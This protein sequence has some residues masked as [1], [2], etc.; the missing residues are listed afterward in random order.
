MDNKI[1]KGNKDNKKNS[2]ERKATKNVE[3]NITKYKR[4]MKPNEY[5]KSEKSKKF[6]DKFVN[7]IQKTNTKV[8]H[9]DENDE[10]NN[11]NKFRNIVNT[12]MDEIEMNE[13]NNYNY[14]TIKVPLK[15]ELSDS[16][17]IFNLD[18]NNNNDKE[19]I[20][21]ILLIQRNYKL[22]KNKKDSYEKL[23][24][25]KENYIPIKDIK[26]FSKEQLEIELIKYINKN[27]ELFNIIKYYRNKINFI[28]FEHK[29]FKEKLNEKKISQFTIN[30]KND[31]NIVNGQQNHHNNPTE[32]KAILKHKKNHNNGK[33]NTKRVSIVEVREVDVMPIKNKIEEN[34]ANIKIIK[35]IND[36]KN[37]NKSSSTG[38]DN[39]A[40]NKNN[41]QINNNID[42]NKIIEDEKEK[43]ERLKKARGLRKIL[44]KKGKE[45]KEILKKYFHKFYLGGI[46]ASIR[47]GI[48]KRTSEIKLQKKRNNSVE[49][50]RGTIVFSDL[51]LL[52]FSK[53]DEEESDESENCQKRRIELLTKIFNRKDRMHILIMKKT[54]EKL[55]LRAKLISLE[56]NRRGRRGS[57]DKTRKRCKHKSKSVSCTNLTELIERNKRE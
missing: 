14:H 7:G 28:E 3:S 44:N 52:N 8:V 19:N 20:K 12:M 17:S 53:N 34:I 45:K 43:K 39:S 46:Y 16:Q 35:N 48:R 30:D 33:E 2:Y 56:Q 55:N 5:I 37:N 41:E 21:N 24:N 49:C 23:M 22:Y 27:K 13:D 11:G 6:Y 18:D 50:R 31:N 1:I 57:T 10:K 25:E 38:I 4:N 9:I 36:E 42:N 26:K 15:C 40:V 51:S 47:R 54:L 29:K 32:K